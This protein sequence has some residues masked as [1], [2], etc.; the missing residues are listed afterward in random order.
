MK[1]DLTWLRVMLEV[2]M[3]KKVNAEDKSK[4]DLDLIWVRARLGFWFV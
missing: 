3:G 2:V 4:R 1:D